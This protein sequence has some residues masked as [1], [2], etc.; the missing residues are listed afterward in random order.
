M[1]TDHNPSHDTNLEHKITT[2][3][4]MHQLVQVEPAA[5]NIFILIKK[6]KINVMMKFN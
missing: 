5:H 6:I 1:A 4:C 3:Y 2:A